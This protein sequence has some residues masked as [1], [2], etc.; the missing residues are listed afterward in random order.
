[1]RVKTTFALI[2]TLVAAA[3]AV[4]ASGHAQFGGL[5]VV[6]IDQIAPAIVTLIPLEGG[7]E[8]GTQACFTATIRDA[9]SV[10]LANQLAR[11][12]VVGAHNLSRSLNGDAAGAAILCYAG[13][14]VGT[15]TITVF[16][17][18]DGDG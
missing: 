18:I 3:L 16:A 6:A 17:D 12:E 10:P 15:D 13:A 1:M 9:N 5:D 11:F 4:P 2:L 14:T 8:T 7:A